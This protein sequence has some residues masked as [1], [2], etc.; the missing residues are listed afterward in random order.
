MNNNYVIKI[1]KIVNSIHITDKDYSTNY[2]SCLT[3]KQYKTS[4]KHATHANINKFSDLFNC[5]LNGAPSML[6]AIINGAHYLLI[7]TDYAT[8]TI[9]VRLIKHKSD[10]S[11]KIIKFCKLI[12]TQFGIK[13]KR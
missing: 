11:A 2:H 12:Y 13:I 3:A 6:P 8:K 10:A 9:F 5:D 1:P 4:Q 7:I